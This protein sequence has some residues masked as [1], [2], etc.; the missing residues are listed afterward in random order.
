MIL[1]G[2]VFNNNTNN[3][4]IKYTVIVDNSSFTVPSSYKV[5]NNSSNFAILTTNNQSANSS[6]C[7]HLLIQRINQSQKDEFSNNMTTD[8]YSYSVSKVNNTYLVNRS[9][10]NDIIE[11][12]EFCRNGDKMYILELCVNTTYYNSNP[13]NRTVPEQLNDIVNDSGYKPI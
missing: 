10:L 13:T 6:N 12:I 7:Y 8:E 2:F 11:Y 9:Y 4:N 3:S 5:V 1:T